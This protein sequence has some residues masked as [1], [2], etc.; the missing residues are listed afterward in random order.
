MTWRAQK[1]FTIVALAAAFLINSLP[2]PP[3]GNAL[4]QRAAGPVALASP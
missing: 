4:A 3:E 2:A 1:I